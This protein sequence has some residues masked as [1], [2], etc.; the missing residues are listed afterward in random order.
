MKAK[1]I[2]RYRHPETCG[3]FPSG[4]WKASNDRIVSF[5]CDR[6]LDRSKQ[7]AERRVPYEI[8]QIIGIGSPGIRRIRSC[9]N[10]RDAFIQAAVEPAV[11]E[12]LRDLTNFLGVPL[13]F[14]RCASYSS[15]ALS[16]ME[17]TVVR[18]GKDPRIPLPDGPESLRRNRD[19]QREVRNS[20]INW[21]ADRILFPL[22]KRLPCWSLPH[23]V[24]TASRG[25]LRRW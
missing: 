2:S 9:K 18:S 19:G 4:I 12:I 6:I 5:A 25:N 8:G 17:S 15:T 21:S 16:R 14:T 11:V 3:I 24:A 1:G 7:S 20:L 13:D 22:I 23:R 10:V